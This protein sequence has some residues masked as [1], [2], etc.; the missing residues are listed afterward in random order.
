M[1]RKV[2]LLSDEMSQA[3]EDF[4]FKERFKTETEAVRWLLTRGLDACVNLPQPEE[5]EEEN[6]C[7]E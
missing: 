3:I 4:R 6:Q 2:Y 1:K 7:H 5:K